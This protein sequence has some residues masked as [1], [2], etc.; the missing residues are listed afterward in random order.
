[1]QSANF[2]LVYLN[3]N[4]LTSFFTKNKKTSAKKDINLTLA[5]PEPGTTSATAC[6]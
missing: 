5:E 3:S 4:L 6:L 1:M 2:L